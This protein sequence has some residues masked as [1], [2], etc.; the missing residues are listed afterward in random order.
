MTPTIS[1]TTRLG[2]V[3]K[4]IEGSIALA[5]SEHRKQILEN[6]TPEELR[7]Y[8]ATWLRWARNDQLPPGDD[9]TTWLIL[10]GRG[11]GKTRAGAEWVRSIALEA[12]SR[13]G[14]DEAGR[15][16]LVG[17]TL[18]DVREVMVGGPSGLLSLDWGAKAPRWI[19]MR[20]CAISAWA[21]CRPGVRRTG[22]TRWCGRC[23]R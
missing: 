9:W 3:P 13:R 4:S 6:A 11:A 19:G 15:I 10:G 22:S 1:A 5:N 20:R 18:A 12:A 23:R 16:A 17:E 14:G 7:E 2:C 21:G 8:S